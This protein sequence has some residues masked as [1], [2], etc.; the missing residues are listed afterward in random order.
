MTDQNS[1]ASHIYNER[2]RQVVQEGYDADHDKGH[3]IEL[4]DAAVSYAAFTS[5]CLE[6]EKDV[7]RGTHTR[8]EADEFLAEGVKIVPPVWPWG[9]SYW[10]PSATDLKRNLVKAGALIAAAIDSLEASGQFHDDQDTLFESEALHVEPTLF[11]GGVITNPQELLFRAITGDEAAQTALQAAAEQHGVKV[12]FSPD[13]LLQAMD[14]EG[15][16]IPA[17]VRELLESLSEEGVG[18]S[19]DA[20][21]ASMEVDDEDGVAVAED[22]E[23]VSDDEDAL[24]RVAQV[25]RKDWLDWDQLQAMTALEPARLN[26]AL[27]ALVSEGVVQRDVNRFRLEG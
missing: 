25:V 1:G 26:E 4:L 16:E 22:E 11:D 20:H 10:K 15:K 3:F 8:A 27:D 9:R 5:A 7:A 18:L 21:P 6:I 2:A 24:D 14:A 23:R 13:Q 19:F 12:A 17:D